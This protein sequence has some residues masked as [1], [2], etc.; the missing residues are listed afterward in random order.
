MVVYCNSTQVLVISNTLFE[1]LKRSSSTRRTRFQQS[2]KDTRDL[3]V[4][5][6]SSG[7]VSLSGSYLTDKIC[8]LC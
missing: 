8:I 4:P 5:E 2:W 7:L 6:L 1:D 3:Y